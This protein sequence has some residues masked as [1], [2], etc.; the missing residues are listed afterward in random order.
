MTTII[1]RLYP[2]TATAEGVAKALVGRGHAAANIDVITGGGDV[3]AALS[4]ARVGKAEAAVY[5]PHV[6]GGAALLVYRAPFNP[7]GAARDG[8][9]TVDAHPW[10]DVGLAKQ[11]VYVRE[12]PQMVK[13][14]KILEGHPLLMT[15]PG[16]VGARRL[17]ASRSGEAPRSSV[18]EGGGHISTRF[19]PM[20]LLRRKESH[21]AIAGGRLMMGGKVLRNWRFSDLIRFDTLMGR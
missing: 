11:N 9:R 20:P 12:A 13:A 14:G 15:R 5:A 17:R 21:S 3:V 2:D 16:S 4:A 10:L 6:E 18:I 8:I 1:T 19:L 7:M